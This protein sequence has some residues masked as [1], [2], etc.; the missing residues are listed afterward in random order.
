MP[1]TP[2]SPRAPA[3]D[4]PSVGPSSNRMAAVY[5][6]PPI[7]A[8][9]QS[10]CSPCPA[11]SSRIKRWSPDLLTQNHLI[12]LGNSVPALRQDPDP[13]VHPISNEKHRLI[14]ALLT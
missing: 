5:G 8:M 12:L 10:S 14:H 13:Q 9:V 1:S 6:L 11:R 3:W 7:P 4:C 2:P